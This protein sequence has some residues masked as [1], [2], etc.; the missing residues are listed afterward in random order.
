MS[1]A[2]G[3]L[4]PLLA[5][6]AA[7]WVSRQ[8][9]LHRPPARALDPD[10]R[11]RLA[12]W[13]SP[14]TLDLVRLRTVPRLDPPSV[15]AALRRVGLSPPLEFERIWGITFVD[16][17]VVVE[18]VPPAEM[19]TLLFHEC[20]HVAQYRLL[21]VRGFL[22]RYVRGWLGAGRRYRGIPLEA[23]AYELA[24]R[25]AA[26]EGPFPVEPEVARRLAARGWGTGGQR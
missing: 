17:I 7:A 12:A 2:A 21:G 25:Y 3:L 5:G 11:S 9:A 14:A 15:L 24:A 18:R 1:P 22:D 26:G 10:P 20:V 6:R 4:A 16:T 23:D 13:F 19:E 8:R